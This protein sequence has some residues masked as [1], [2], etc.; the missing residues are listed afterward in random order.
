MIKLYGKVT[1]FD[2]NPIEGAIVEIK[3]KRFETVYR[4]ISDTEGRY[5]LDVDEGRYIA[6]YVCKEY[7]AKNLEYWAWNVLAYQDLEINPRIDGLEVYAINAWVPQG[8]MPSVQIYFRPMSLRRAKEL[9][10]RLGVGFPAS[11]NE[12][13]SL[14]VID[15]APKLTKED[16]DVTVNNQP[17][18]VFEINRLMEAIGED[19]SMHAYVVQTS[20]PKRQMCLDYSRINIV[21]RDKETGETGEGCLF[22]KEP[23]YV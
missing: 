23:S 13:K 6:M 21:L 3:N 10:Q 16:I 20:S 8:A 15:I 19:Q 22:W 7:A 1:D 12:L 18:E 11:K 14:E 5:R 4:T 17:V 2:S 9:S